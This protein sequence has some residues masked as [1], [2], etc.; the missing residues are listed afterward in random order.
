MGP[1]LGSSTI[2]VYVSP[3]SLLTRTLC[4]EVCCELAVNLRNLE[5]NLVGKC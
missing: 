5:F 2:G 4:L 3:Y 1:L